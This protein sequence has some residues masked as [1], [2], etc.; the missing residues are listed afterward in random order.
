VRLSRYSIIGIMVALLLSAVAIMPVFGAATGTVTLSKTFVSPTGEATITVDDADLNSL[1]SATQAIDVAFG[2]LGVQAITLTLNAGNGDNISGI[3]TIGTPTAGGQVASNYSLSVFNAA[4]GAITIQAFSASTGNAEFVVSYKLATVG[5]TT[6]KVTSPSDATGITVTLTE[7]GADTGVFE[8]TFG[9]DSS[10]SNDSTD[11]ILAVA[12]QVVTVKYTD[13]SPAGTRQDTLTVED[14]EPSGVLVSPANKSFTTSKSPKLTVDFTD[15]DS[16]VDAGT[17]AFV[18]PLKL[19]SALTTI[20]SDSSTVTTSTITNGFRAVM[21]IDASVPV[22]AKQTAVI[23]WYATATDK[24]GNVGRTDADGSTSGDQDFTLFLDATGPDFTN[25]VTASAGAWWNAAKSEVEDDVTKSV[26][27]S[28]GIKLGNILDLPAILAYSATENDKT[29]GLNASTVT[30]A[31]FEIDGLKGADGVTSNDLTPSAAT[32]YAGA[33]NWIFLTVPAMAPD[34]APTVLL[35]DGAG[36]ISDTAGNATTSGTK[37]TL[38]KQAPAATAV[39]NR[40]LDDKDATLTITTNEASIVPTVVYINAG[41]SS[42]LATATV[43]L[44]STGVYEAKIAPTTDGIQSIKV[45][46]ADGQSNLTVLGS[47]A[48]PASDFPKSGTIALYI[49]SAVPAPTVN[50]NNTAAS[51]ATVETSNPFFVTAIFTGEGKEY[52]LDSSGEL[53]VTSSEVLTGTDLDIHNT[54]TIATATLDDVSIL[55][56]VDTQDNITFNMAVLD[57]A[58]GAHELVI[59]GKDTAGNEVSTGTLKFTVTARKAYKVGVSAGWNLM[60]F[61][62]DPAN[63]DISAVLPA[64]HPATDVL[65]FDDGVWSVASRAAGGAWEGT[66]TSIDGKHGYWINTTS[67]EPVEALLSLPSVGSAATLPT[68]SVE[69][70]WN[71]ISVIDLAQDTSASVAGS[72]YFTSIDWAVAYTYSSSTR[73]WTRVTPTAGSVSNGQGVWVWA[74]KAGT[75]IP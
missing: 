7:S 67:S 2:A 18:I 55:G 28:I 65:S 64:A 52:G 75:L 15:N 23:R 63:G 25:A 57:I 66:L 62:G 5:T 70:G 3:P 38:D 13:A 72:A 34:A 16:L 74:N 51:G 58:T 61:P 6:A 68:I 39:L 17:I 43:S 24:A 20:T 56:L 47:T 73:A 10:A 49:D 36:G 19:N 50:V 30:A 14:T 42:S 59:V 37:V 60:S 33:P 22:D 71:L 1:T 44:V 53:T 48:T 54:V 45:T 40:S 32:V 41:V 26:N 69:A 35:K 29:E 21:T 27:T 9:V 12:G 8:G 11:K 31:D 4:T 46:V